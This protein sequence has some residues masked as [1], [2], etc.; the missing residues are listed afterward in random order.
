M[1]FHRV[2]CVSDREPPCSAADVLAVCHGFPDRKAQS[3]ISGKLLCVGQQFFLLL[4]GP[5]AAVERLVQRIQHEVPEAGLT[6]RVRESAEERSFGGWSIGDVYLD[7]IGH[8]DLD[9]A[10]E[11]G[12]LMIDL[13][14]PPTAPA[15]TAETPSEEPAEDETEAEDLSDPF[16]QVAALLD[17][18]AVTPGVRRQREAA[19][20]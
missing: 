14:A 16:A 18:F 8:A 15:P 10:K 2:V 12:D 4:D 7:E 13:L 5:Y 3:G 9:A 17:R 1:S 19:A 6:V 11:L 20:A